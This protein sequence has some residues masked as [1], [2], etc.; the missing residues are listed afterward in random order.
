MAEGAGLRGLDARVQRGEIAPVVNVISRGSWIVGQIGTKE[1]AEV[2]FQEHLHEGLY[3]QDRPRHRAAAEQHFASTK[4]QA[5]EIAQQFGD[6]AS[7]D[8]LTLLHC[9]L[10]VAGSGLKVPVLYLRHEAVDAWWIGRP[11]LITEGNGG[12]FFLGAAL[13]FGG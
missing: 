13:P 3:E 9:A 7:D 4:E 1:Q 11:E 5:R 8:A 10:L 2:L 12:G 6:S